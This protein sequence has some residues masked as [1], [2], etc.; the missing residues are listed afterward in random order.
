M[1]LLEVK[2]LCI[3]YENEQKSQAVRDLSFQIEKGEMVGLVGVSGCGKSSAVL[4]ISG[5]LPQNAGYSCEKLLFDGE[6]YTL[7]GKKI[8]MVFQ[9]P[10]AYLNPLVKIG[11][12]LTETIQCHRRCSKKEAKERAEELLSMVGIE[13]PSLRMNQYPFEVS[14]GMKQRVVIAIALACEPDL[15]IADEPTTAL[16]VTVQR[17][18]LELFLKEQKQRF[19]WSAMILASLRLYVTEFWSCMRERSWRK[20]M[21][22]KSFIG[23]STLIHNSWLKKPGK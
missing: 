20:A 4:G 9:D 7:P 22:R 1:S 11:C 23:R 19:F 8:A 3:W 2:R 6:A 5:L 12:Q 21:C 10:S 16:D 18:I 14:G 13:S 15:V 17:Q